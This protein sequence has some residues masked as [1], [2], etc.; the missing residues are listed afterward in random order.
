VA[1][2]D[3]LSSKLVRRLELLDACAISDAMDVHG[4]DG[5]VSGLSALTGRSRV[6]GRMVTVQLGIAQRTTPSRVHLGA[7]AITL[8][9][10]GDVILVAND[11]RLEMG[12]WGGVLSTAAR[13]KGVAGVIVDGAVRDVDEAVELGLSIYGRM[14]TP[15]TA[16]GRVS[17]ISTNEPV[18]IASVRVEPGD[19][20]LADGTGVVMIPGTHAEAVITTAE[21]IAARE[22]AMVQRL[23]TGSSI[24]DVMGG[25]YETMLEPEE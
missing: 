19:L 13:M 12:A 2:D 23:Y 14:G 22:H 11:G 17:E 7:T 10:P 18:T 21:T 24:I 20:V 25:A 15:R 1:L 16:R 8:A 5:V 6:V 3:E 4:L 9:A